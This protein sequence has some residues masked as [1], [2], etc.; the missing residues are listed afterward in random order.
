MAI[1][2]NVNAD[3]GRIMKGSIS[4][5]IYLIKQKKCRFECRL[6]LQNSFY[7]FSQNSIK[8]LFVFQVHR[9]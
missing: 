6:Y 4:L 9:K 1:R 2:E 5:R 3:A 8:V 7:T